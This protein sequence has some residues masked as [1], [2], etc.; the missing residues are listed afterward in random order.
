MTYADDVVMWMWAFALLG[1]LLAFGLAWRGLARSEEAVGH[2]RGEL[3]GLD[4][5]APARIELDE[6]TRA[7]A[8][9]RV[10]LHTRAA[11]R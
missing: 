10:R 5:L 11:D 2:L 3:D 8:G 4:A 6:A 1:T 9:D 7:T